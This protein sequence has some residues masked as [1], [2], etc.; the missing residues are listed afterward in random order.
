[1]NL[2]PATEFG[3]SE[4]SWPVMFPC[5][6]CLDECILEPWGTST[7]LVGNDE[8]RFVCISTSMTAVLLPLLTIGQ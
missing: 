8:I 1:M 3:V 2:L 6:L 5:S 4:A 7:F